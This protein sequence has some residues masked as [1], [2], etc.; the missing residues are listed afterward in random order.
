MQS[1]QRADYVSFASLDIRIGK[2]VSAEFF[3]EAKKPAYKM[4][5]DFGAEIGTKRTSAQITNL[6][7]P[8]LLVGTLVV[9]VVNFPPK[10]IAGYES[11]V[12]VLGAT[13]EQGEVVL[14]KPERELEL[15]SRIS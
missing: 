7:T 13:N 5:I 10:R 9:A 4:T 6:Y 11:E 2:I 15:G 1:S 12:L 3:A 14:L 8:D